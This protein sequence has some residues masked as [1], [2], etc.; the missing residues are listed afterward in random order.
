MRLERDE[1]LKALTKQASEKSLQFDERDGRIAELTVQVVMLKSQ[2]A[3]ALRPS[4]YGRM[5][6]REP[7]TSASEKSSAE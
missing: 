4:S 1:I 2:L 3:E 5:V 6:A 7:K